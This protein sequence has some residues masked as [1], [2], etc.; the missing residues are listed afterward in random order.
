MARNQRDDVFGG[1][2]GCLAP[3]L[4]SPQPHERGGG[5][6]PG[7]KGLEGLTRMPSSSGDRT[8]MSAARPRNLDKK[9]QIGTR[10]G[11]CSIGCRAPGPGFPTDL[12]P[13]AR[14]GWPQG[15]PGEEAKALARMS[16]SPREPQLSNPPAYGDSPR[17]PKAPSALNTCRG[18]RKQRPITGVPPPHPTWPWRG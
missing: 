11:G 7:E 10:R 8:V 4:P 17:N 3:S 2:V 1:V 15:L 6:E 14:Q 9:A 12:T 18:Q 13:P 5:G 16:L